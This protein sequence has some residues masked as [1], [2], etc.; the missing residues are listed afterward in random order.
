MTATIPP[1][2]SRTSTPSPVPPTSTPQ[3]TDT[4]T[5]PPPPD[6]SIAA[7]DVY[8]YPVPLIYAGDLVTFQV[9][10]FVPDIVTPGDVTV[11]VLVDEVKV[12][13]GGLDHRNLAGDPFG[14]FEWA[15]DTADQTGSHDVTIILDR[16][17]LIQAGDE[18]DDNNRVAFP[19]TVYDPELLPE[20][21]R[22]A[23]WVTAQTDCCVVHVVSGTAAY[24][25]LPQ[26]LPVVETAV[27]QATDKLDEQ[28]QQQLDLFLINR[29][30]GQGGYAG[31]AM[32]VS[33]L[34]RDYVSGNL[35]QVITHEAVHL[36]DRQFAPNRIPF[37]AEGVAVWASNGHYKQEDLDAK[38]AALL[39]TGNY[40]PLDKLIEDFYPVQHEIGY[41]EAAGLVSYLTQ[42]YGWSQVR[43]FYS[44]VTR[45][46]ADTQ[47]AAVD[48]NLQQ[49]F[50]R[51]LS[52]IEAD[53]L[54][55]LSMT[56]PS[57]AAVQDLEATIDYYNTIR[58][59]QTLYDPTAHFLTAWLPQPSQVESEGNPAD[60]T[61]HPRP[62]TNITLEVML[63]ATGSAIAEGRYT[64]ARV[65][66]DSIN[67]VLDNEGQFGD[68]LA[69]SYWDIVV[70]AA[71]SG[72]E[73]QQ[74]D[75]AGKQARVQ[76][77]Q[78]DTINLTELIL[79]L[80]K[81]GWMLSN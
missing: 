79:V 56:P 22:D 64:R 55:F 16:D 7:E 32:V 15:W 80:G 72:Y 10:A 34:D 23:T 24:R 71:E 19:V 2:P 38:A 3:P 12:A 70:A 47:A 5:P 50:G 78:S 74:V 27:Q 29:V 9:T 42:T 73:V 39:M 67:R 40:Y 65:L 58:H 31:S 11:H 59:Y 4:A 36:I 49:Y 30:I 43:A 18:N 61:R 1:T 60:L 45:D 62:L 63:H 35:E 13:S 51:S 44:D 14:V 33:Y 41:A 46:D 75:L 17:D 28:P 53:W 21:E 77:S 25:D 26:I 37:L 6:L 68:P 57:R 69:N 20:V 48:L 54:D 81:Q 76:A 52:Q 8:L 66:L